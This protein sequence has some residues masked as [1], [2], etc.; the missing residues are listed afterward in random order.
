MFRKIFGRLL[1]AGALPL[2]G[3]ALVA[4]TLLYFSYRQS[5]EEFERTI[6]AQ[7]QSEVERFVVATKDSFK[8]FV[9]ARNN[10]DIFGE[11]VSQNLLK[12]YVIDNPELSDIS[13]IKT[14]ATSRIPREKGEKES[15]ECYEAERLA[16]DQPEGYEIARIV[17]DTSDT[18]LR[19]FL[20][21]GAFLAAREGSFVFSSVEWRE[22]TPFVRITAPVKNQETE[23]II[24]VLNGELR[25]TRLLSIFRG[26][27]FGESGN[28]F[29]LDE[30]GRVLAHSGGASFLQRDA[31]GLP[32][33]TEFSRAIVTKESF[34]GDRVLTAALPMTT[35]R[36]TFV[37]EWPVR[38]AFAP[39]VSLLT[40]ILLIGLLLFGAIIVLANIQ[41]KEIVKPIRALQVAAV[42]IGK[43]DFV[44]AA[45]V[46]THDE[47]EDLAD[48][49]NL[50]R[51]DLT[52]LQEVRT[53][54]VR[55]QAL[56]RAFEKEQELFEAKDVLLTTA[57]HQFRTPISVLNWNIGLLKQMPLTKEAQELV[58]GIAEH[59]ENLAMIAGDLLNATAFGA[60][61]VAD[62]SPKS[63]D[64][65]QLL[66]EVVG[67]YRGRAEEKKLRFSW[68]PPSAP[69]PMRGSYGALR[70]MFEN[71]VANAVTYTPSGGEISLLLEGTADAVRCIVRD[72]G[73]G[74]PESEQSHL[75]SSFF[76]ASNAIAARN[77]GTGLGLFIARNI[78]VGHG[79]VIDVSSKEGAGATF[80][81][82]LPRHEAQDGSVKE[83]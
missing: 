11:C 15:E 41:A 71:L 56:T 23:E 33:R 47:L 57:S 2:F 39:L 12:G 44:K 74:I 27:G 79:G 52:R 29:L 53:A 32:V 76:R 73:I 64:A 48:A 62:P 59:A 19:S 66:E 70:A 67:R 49:L 3:I 18:E 24:A 38:D 6:L 54:E 37:A 4:T 80:T 34:S 13:F 21:D 63:F 35:A 40:R 50:M 36:W 9:N 77:V 43:G 75:F 46:G 83:K 1:I 58:F 28:V 61:Y 51:A 68:S 69:I 30:A 78:A 55:A 31:S 60:G 20:N 45:H 42:R 10:T 25:L 82:M 26:S 7:K 22:G 65:R 14:T 5:A 81:V 8:L 16:Y 72:T 17:P